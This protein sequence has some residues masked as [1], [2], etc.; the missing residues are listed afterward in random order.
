MSELAFS[1]LGL[2]PVT[3]TPP[4]VNDLGAVAGGL[5]LEQLHQ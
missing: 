1:G 3:Q 2:N 4:C 5:H